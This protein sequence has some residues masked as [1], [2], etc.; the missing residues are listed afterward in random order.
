MTPV[1]T[2]RSTG[3][4]VFEGSCGSGSVAAACALSLGGA[5][6]WH[7]FTLRQP[8]GTIEAA[9]RLEGGRAAEGSIGG[10][11]SVGRVRA[12]DQEAPLEKRFL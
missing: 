5:G 1:V 4:T 8:R 3:T 12:V 2:V 9:V 10:A 11:V 7:R 6:G